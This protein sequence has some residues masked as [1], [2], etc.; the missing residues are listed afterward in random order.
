MSKGLGVQGSF[1]KQHGQCCGTPCSGRLANRLGRRVGPGH[2]APGHVPLSCS[3]PAPRPRPAAGT[4]CGAV[5]ARRSTRPQRQCSRGLCVWRRAV[6]YSSERGTA[7]GLGRRDGTPL[8]LVKKGQCGRTGGRGGFLDHSD[9]FSGRLGSDAEASGRG[10]PLNSV[11]G[12][13]CKGSCSPDPLL[14]TGH[15]KNLI[16]TSRSTTEAEGESGMRKET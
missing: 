1:W 15:E 7:V 9:L 3:L 10:L 12:C 8:L 11:P 4:A 5:T 6:S 14:L 2:R 13:P 16:Q